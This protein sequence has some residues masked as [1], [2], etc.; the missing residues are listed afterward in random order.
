MNIALDI[1]L[2]DIGVWGVAGIGALT[3]IA[4]RAVD[5]ARLVSPP[6]APAQDGAGGTVESIA[7][8]RKA[9]AA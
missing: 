4:N 2:G 5:R 3:F 6:K 7:A 1:A 9:G 8:A